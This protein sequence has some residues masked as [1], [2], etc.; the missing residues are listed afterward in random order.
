ML[1]C[2][3]DQDPAIIQAANIVINR[4]GLFGTF[5]FVPVVDGSF[6]VRSPIKSL[7]SGRVNGVCFLYDLYRQ[8]FIIFA[9]RRLLSV[10]NSNEAQIFVNTTITNVNTR[11]Y[12]LLLFPTFKSEQATAVSEKYSKLGT[13]AQQLV[14]IQSDCGYSDPPG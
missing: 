3:R 5:T 12:S 4:A 9:Q 1:A 7:A 2:L 6:I 14:Q 13:T 11:D 8:Y 10:T